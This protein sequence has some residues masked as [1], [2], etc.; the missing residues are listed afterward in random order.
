MGNAGYFAGV[1]DDQAVHPHVCGERLPMRAVAGRT[2]GSS[3]RVWGTLRPF[4]GQSFFGRFI[5][6]CVGNAY[7][8]VS[9]FHYPPVHPH[10]CGERPCYRLQ[11]CSRAG[12]SPRVWGTL[13]ATE[14]E[15][16]RYRFIPTCVGNA[17]HPICAW[18][19]RSV[20]PHVCGERIEPVNFQDHRDGS[21]PRVWGTRYDD[22]NKITRVRFIPTCVGNAPA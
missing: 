2:A 19:Y 14:T 9:F 8:C 16:D 3:P 5:P 18:E 17:D 4:S 10:V 20:H 1:A 12:S 22:K 13:S 7:F 6:T 11:L 21:S 15:L